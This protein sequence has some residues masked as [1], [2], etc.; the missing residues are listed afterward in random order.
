[1]SIQLTLM[2]KVLC[3]YFQYLK[4]PTF[5]EIKKKVSTEHNYHVPRDKKYTSIASS[6]N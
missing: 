3:P 2:N 1:M 5:P 4:K 6:F